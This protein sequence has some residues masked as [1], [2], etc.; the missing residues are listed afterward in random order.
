MDL[1]REYTLNV[2]TVGAKIN[3]AVFIDEKT[4][5]RHI[6]LGGCLPLR[7]RKTCIAHAHSH[8]GTPKRRVPRKL[9]SNEALPYKFSANAG[10]GA[11]PIL[12]ASGRFF[13]Q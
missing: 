5:Q 4:C 13:R 10:G 2:S 3:T 8:S 12:C 9:N 1:K 7:S 6:V 11:L